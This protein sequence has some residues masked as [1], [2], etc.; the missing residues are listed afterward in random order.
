[1]HGGRLTR[2][3][4]ASADT[5]KYLSQLASVSADTGFAVCAIGEADGSD[6]ALPVYM[7]S[8]GFPLVLGLTDGEAALETDVVQ[9]LCGMLHV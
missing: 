8:G 9:L 4:S 3:R 2:G 5:H 6:A 7:C 1:M